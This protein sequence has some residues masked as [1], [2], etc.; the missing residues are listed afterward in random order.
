METWDFS[1]FSDYAGLRAG[2][3][4]NQLLAHEW[5][6]LSPAQ[7]YQQSY[8]VINEAALAKIW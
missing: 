8:E 3:L 2:T 1:S 5:L 6:D 7:F 4:C